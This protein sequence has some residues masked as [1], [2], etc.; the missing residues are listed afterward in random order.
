MKDKELR[1]EISKAIN[2]GWV[3]Y[4]DFRTDEA[5]DQV[6]KMIKEKLTIPVVVSTSCDLSKEQLKRKIQM[7][8][9]QHQ[10][11]RERT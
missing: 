5:V 11:K 8:D 4:G 3:S 6:F 1:Q 2:K 9:M 7:A 10:I